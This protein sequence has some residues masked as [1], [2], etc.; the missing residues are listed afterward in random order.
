L[1]TQLIH[2][3]YYHM[4]FLTNG[5]FKCGSVIW[6]SVSTRCFEVDYHLRAYKGIIE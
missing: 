4:L 6:A 2:A 5:G 1:L 3:K